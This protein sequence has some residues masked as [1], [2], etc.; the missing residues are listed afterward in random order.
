MHV[1]MLFN[2]ETTGTVSVVLTSYIEWYVLIFNTLEQ[3]SRNIKQDISDSFPV[4]VLIY[5]NVLPLGTLLV[6]LQP[7]STGKQFLFQIISY[8][9]L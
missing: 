9:I 2:K 1:Y 8:V 5:E 6:F 3:D 4:H 7:I